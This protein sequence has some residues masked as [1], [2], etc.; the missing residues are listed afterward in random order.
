MA[1]AFY[2]NYKNNVGKIDWTDNAGTTIKVMLVDDTYS[3]D[4]DS[5]LNKNDIDGLSVEVS[6]TNYVAGGASLAN[7]ATSIDNVNDRAEYDADDVTWA[8][9]DIIAR[10]GII[11]LDTGNAS[12]STLISYVDF[13][14]NK[15][16]SQGDFVIQWNAGGV[17]RIA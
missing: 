17:F 10:G 11:Y 6:G 16:S 9:S 2:N 13:G 8:S 5:H 15:I 1:N 3:L 12:T 4:I 14:V 7:R